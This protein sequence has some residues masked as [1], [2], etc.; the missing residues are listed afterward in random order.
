M[1]AAAGEISDAGF[2]AAQLRQAVVM[3]AAVGREISRAVEQG[4]RIRFLTHDFVDKLKTK[5]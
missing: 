1:T 5:S 2:K 3:I 4:M